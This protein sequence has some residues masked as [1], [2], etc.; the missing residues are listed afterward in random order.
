MVDDIEYRRNLTKTTHAC[1]SKFAS[2]CRNKKERKRKEKVEASIPRPADIVPVL[3]MREISSLP[4]KTF[5]TAYHV[6]Y[7]A[8]PW[9]HGLENVVTVGLQKEHGPHEHQI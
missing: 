4:I 2:T 8:H 3:E 1:L 5:H 9:L 6:P 7:P